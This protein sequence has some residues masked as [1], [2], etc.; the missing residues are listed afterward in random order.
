MMA[1]ESNL[2]LVGSYEN[3]KRLENYL[4]DK[5]RNLLSFDDLRLAVEYI[6]RS[7]LRSA[8][9]I[10]GL[11][12]GEILTNKSELEYLVANNDKAIKLVIVGDGFSPSEINQL[13]ELGVY[14]YFIGRHTSS[15][16]LSYMIDAYINQ[17]NS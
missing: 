14:K 9:V 8:M 6:K 15:P 16:G 10:T 1:A 13:H 7:K 2:I 17:S 5:K 4:R 12:T 3:I 11:K